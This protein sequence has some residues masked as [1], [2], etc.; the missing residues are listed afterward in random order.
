MRPVGSWTFR[1]FS[2]KS[3]FAACYDWT[4]D[5]S[6]PTCSFRWIGRILYFPT[7]PAEREPDRLKPKILAPCADSEAYLDSCNTMNHE[8]TSSSDLEGFSVGFRLVWGCWTRG[9]DRSLD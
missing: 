8:I 3:I 1:I 7:S 5:R 2:F 4:P 9:A 6:A